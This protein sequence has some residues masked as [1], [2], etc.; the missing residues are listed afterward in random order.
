MEKAAFYKNKALLTG[1]VDLNFRKE[2]VKRY[3]W[4]IAL[5]G[6]ETWT[7]LKIDQKYL[8]RFEP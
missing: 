3:I 1:I 5:Y 4:S 2:P 8:N 7:R 6:A